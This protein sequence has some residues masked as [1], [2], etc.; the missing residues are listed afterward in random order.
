[1]DELQH[2]NKTEEETSS[3]TVSLA[4]PTLHVF[5]KI[6]S[7]GIETAVGFS[8]LIFSFLGVNEK[9]RIQ[10]RSFCRVFRDALKPVPLWTSFPHPKYPTLN[11]L[12]DKLN[13]VYHKDST[14]SPKVCFVMEGTFHGNSRVI[15]KYPIQII[16]AGKNK[17][18]LSGYG[19]H[20]GGKKDE[21]KSVVLKDM[22]MMRS[23]LYGLVVSNGLSFLCDSMTFTECGYS[24]VCAKNTKGRLIN[25]VITQCKSSGIYC[26]KNALIELEGSQT[27]VDGNGTDVYSDYYGLETFDTSSIIHLLSP[28]VK[29][30]ISTNN[31]GGRNFGNRY[32]GTIQT[33]N[34]FNLL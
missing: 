24:G 21:R 33:V 8:L 16:G 7:L 31:H 5:E 26:G 32:G 28:L 10:L 9:D 30:S 22:T 3:S 34:T 4:A 17:T 23:R 15:I 13:D 6:I 29:E 2:Q 27:K 20:I 1:M 11:D 12:M 18:F 25:C 14:K 19:I